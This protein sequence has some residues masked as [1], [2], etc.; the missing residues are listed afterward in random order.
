[1]NISRRKTFKTVKEDN[2]SLFEDKQ[3]TSK[4]VHKHSLNSII[5]TSGFPTQ[6]Q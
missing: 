6:A 3:S 1:M 4:A 5:Y 2:F